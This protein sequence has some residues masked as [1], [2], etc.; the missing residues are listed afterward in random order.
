MTEPKYIYNKWIPVGN[1]KLMTVKPYVFIR[2][3]Y[4]GKLV[5]SDYT[6]EKIHII[7]QTEMTVIGFFLLYILEYAI[8]LLLTF[9]HHRAYRS[10]STEQ[11]AYA[12]QNRQ[13]YLVTREKYAWR[14]YIFKLKKK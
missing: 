4:K 2:E 9:S 5:P 6:H 8:K 1:G 3:E 13:S 14:K 12:N 10:I 7:Q 11:E